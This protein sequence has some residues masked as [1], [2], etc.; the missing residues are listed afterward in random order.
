M[1]YLADVIVPWLDGLALIR[2]GDHAEGYTK[3]TSALK[4][5]RDGGGLF[6]VPGTNAARAAALMGLRRF[7]EARALLDEAVEI[8][9]RTDHRMH[10][11]EVHR[12]LGE[13]HL[14]GLIII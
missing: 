8:I 5:W 1:T 9:N 3:V 4:V 7:A 11:A 12:V 10:E 13:L 2:H 6:L 14:Q